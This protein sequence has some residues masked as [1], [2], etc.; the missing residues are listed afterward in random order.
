MKVINEWWPKIGSFLKNAVHRSRGGGKINEGTLITSTR[1]SHNTNRTKKKTTGSA[2]FFQE[3]F[4]S[5]L[6]ADVNG[7][8][9]WSQEIAWGNDYSAAGQARRTT[10]DGGALRDHGDVLVRA[11]QLQQQERHGTE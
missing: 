10:V 7:K 6:R 4:T 8:L 2:T 5:A 11:Q 9:Q 1:I 3:D